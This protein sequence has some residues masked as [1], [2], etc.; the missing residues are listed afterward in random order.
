V[1]IAEIFRQRVDRRIEEVIK[2][3]LGDEAVVAEEIDEYVVTDHIREALENVLERYQETILKPDEGTT[4][5]VS[6]FFG[7]GKSSFA[8]VLGYL[9]ANPTVLGQNATERFLARTSSKKLE[10]LLNTIHQQA[11]TISVFVDLSTGT[12][13]SREGESISRPLYRAL[14]RT[15]GYSTN[16]TLAE[17]EYDLETDGDLD[18][19]VDKFN[20]LPDSKGTW[21]E[22]RNVLLAR[23]EASQAMRLLRP[24]TFPHADSWSKSATEPDITPNWFADRAVELLRRRRADIKRVIF[25]VDE[26][27]QYVA[28]SVQRMLDLQGVAQAIQKKKAPLWLLATSQEKL[29][30]VVD[31]LESKQ[32]ELAR[33]QDRFPTRVDLLPA[34][35]DEV[36]G[37]R[38]LEKNEPGQRAVREAIARNRNQLSANLRLD[39][40]TRPTEASEEELVRLYPLIP[41]QI[42]LLIDAISARR[43]HGGATPMLGGSNRTIIK[44][45]QQL[46]I[47]PTVGLG[48]SDVGALVAL[49]R[50]Y[51]LLEPIMPTSWRAEI[52][53]I[54]DRHGKDS[55]AA[56]VAK[57]VALTMDVRALPLTPENIA[58]LLHPSTSA[59]STRGKVAEAIEILVKEE[60][61]RLG[62]N[63][64]RLQSP[65][66]KDWE[67]TRRGIDPRP[68]D[69]VRLR[70][71]LLDEALSGLSVT[72]GEGKTFKIEIAVEGEK[73]SQGQVRLNIE[74]ADERRLE[75]LRALSRDTSSQASLWWTFV[76]SASTYEALV[77]FHRS[78]QM[79]KRKDAATK[80]SGEL[81]LLGEERTRLARKEREALK[82]LANDLLAGKTLFRGEIEDAEGTELKSAAQAMLAARIGEIYPRLDQFAAPIGK[83]DVMALL[84]SDDLRGLASSPLGDDGIGLLRTTPDGVE[85][86][87]GQ[88]PLVTFFDE[89]RERVGYGTEAT[90]S[91]L[92]RK[93]GGPPFGAPIEAVMALAAAG[94]RTGLIE[95]VH[96]GARLT[97]PE[98]ARLDK[99]FG[100]IPAFRAASF[101]PQTE[102]DI[103]IETRTAVAEKLA[104]LIGEQ[105]S[106][107]VDVLGP[108]IRDLFLAGAPAIER[109][110]S[111]LRALGLVVPEAVIRTSALVERLRS[112][113]DAE[114]VRTAHEAWADLIDGSEAISKLDAVL[115]EDLESLQAAKEQIRL[116]AY[117]LTEEAAE[118]LERLEDLLRA[119]DYVTNLGQIKTMSKRIKSVRDQVLTEL[120]SE[121]R[122]RVEKARERVIE[123]FPQLDPQILDDA[124]RPLLELDPSDEDRLSVDTLLA[125]IDAVEARTSQ[126]IKTLEDELAPEVARVVVADII[127]EVISNVEELDIA[128]KRVKEAVEA[129]LAQERQVRLT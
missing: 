81:E 75:E 49:D 106:P 41:Y 120:S 94:L 45:A 60:V 63:G 51:D 2:V 95:V 82:H 58:V 79:V 9:L 80:S 124:I 31:A 88:D 110:N 112:A 33:V 123:R 54:Q 78:D 25:V 74:E 23:G 11:P 117:G 90:G 39:S 19:F 17:L 121:V 66:E 119:G 129:E 29:Q 77:E 14:L 104:P 76:E 32:I 107:A 15:L 20:S 118:E 4:L 83:P 16:F 102:G 67:K 5:W 114:A 43:A 48:R 109:V 12:D 108:K 8:K 24:E 6:G 40:R 89:I 57:V 96:Q 13:V 38:I 37:K 127:R 101:R 100:T 59:E 84:R 93:F 98:D 53:R 105:P 73:V 122:A 62:D 21:D 103:P 86:A 99:V 69:L 52:E 36:A 10:A 27:G 128:L 47:H 91:H 34:D 65:Q 116:G 72:V 18:A 26:V 126:V 28:R 44:L 3:D 87:T 46:I 64:Y 70:R 35:I 50:A 68:A 111:A 7:S 1:K 97:R 85:I 125:R 92:E 56:K 30:D 113:D 71:R 115:V 61:I 42:E 55:D 22:R